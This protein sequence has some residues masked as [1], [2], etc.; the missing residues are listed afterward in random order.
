MGLISLTEEQEL[1]ASADATDESPVEME[2][3]AQ[4]S[5]AKNNKV[6]ISVG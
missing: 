1:R 4:Q 3:T 5:P 6:R 2:A